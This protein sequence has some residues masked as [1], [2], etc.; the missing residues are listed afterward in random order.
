MR[1]GC[2]QST[3]QRIAAALG[4]N[5]SSFRQK[6]VDLPNEKLVEI[7]QE[8]ELLKLFCA[9][10]DAEKRLACL[11]FVRALAQPIAED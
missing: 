8:L 6:N 2:T 9:V 7:S 1:D 3:V 11:D 4:I 5:E 10:K